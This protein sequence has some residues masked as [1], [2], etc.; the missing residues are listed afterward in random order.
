VLH[1]WN[2]FFPGKNA[3]A[4]VIA[5]WLTA[6]LSLAALGL[7]Y[8]TRMAINDA[9]LERERLRALYLCKAM[10][11]RAALAIEQDTNPWNAR[12]ESWCAH[13]DFAEEG[14]LDEMGL[15]DEEKSD[16]KCEYAVWDE[17]GKINV[18]VAGNPDLYY[19][20]TLQPT[21]AS[22]ILD[23]VSPAG[24]ARPGG[25]Q[26]DYYEQ[27]TPPYAA[28]N[29]PIQ[30]LEELLSV[31]GITPDLFLGTPDHSTGLDAPYSVGMRE[32]LTVYGDG[33]ININTAAPE[34]IAAI[35]P[36]LS[37]ATVSYIAQCV[38]GPDGVLGT[39][40]D[41]PFT[42]LSEL[43]GVPGISDLELAILTAACTVKSSV[44]SILCRVTVGDGKA[45]KTVHA[46]IA[47]DAVTGHVQTIAWR[48][49]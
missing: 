28:K 13:L 9:V 25:A 20:N 11:A 37:E 45:K 33:L 26:S 16:V 29:A 31:K 5:L 21:Q 19:L 23:W 27:L 46:V 12:S 34:V 8:H 41:V 32:D 14:W 10:V 22:A 15:S 24:V 6:I 4:L 39:S 30:A 2:K 17:S 43:A 40:D 18:N 7:A 44:F 36:Y 49:Y 42:D 47:R 1:S 35:S 38:R 48:E 3:A